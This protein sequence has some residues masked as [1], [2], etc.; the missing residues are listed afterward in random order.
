MANGLHLARIAELNRKDSETLIDMAGTSSRD[1]KTTRIAT[2]I[3][4]FYLPASLV[5]VSP[6]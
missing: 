4:M 2:M 5:L 6:P 3:A 1:S